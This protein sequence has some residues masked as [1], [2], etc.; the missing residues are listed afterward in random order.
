[1]AGARHTPLRRAF[2]RTAISQASDDPNSAPNGTATSPVAETVKE[3]VD[4]KLKEKGEGENKPAPE[5]APPEETTDKD[6]KEEAEADTVA[7]AIKKP[8]ARGEFGSAAAR[9]ANR[10]VRVKELPPIALPE[11]FMKNNVKRRG[12]IKREDRVAVNLHMNVLPHEEWCKLEQIETDEVRMELDGSKPVLGYLVGYEDGV[13]KV[14]LNPEC[15]EPKYNIDFTPYGE[16]LS[17]INAG[18]KLRPPKGIDAKDVIRPT[19]VIRFDKRNGSAYLDALVNTIAF[20]LKSDLVRIDCDDIAQIVGEYI[21]ENLAWKSSGKRLLGYKAPEAAIPQRR[22]KRAPMQEIED[23]GEEEQVPGVVSTDL[24]SLMNFS[25]AYQMDGTMITFQELFGQTSV[26]SST[27]SE[28]FSEPWLDFK[29]KAALEAIIDASLIKLSDEIASGPPKAESSEEHPVIIHVPGYAELI[30]TTGGIEIINKLKEIINRRWIDGRKILLIGTSV[31]DPQVP[32]TS[33]DGL[34]R[35]SKGEIVDEQRTVWI[36]GPTDWN[37]SDEPFKMHEKQRI[38]NINL[39][40]VEEMIVNMTGKPENAALMANVEKWLPATF[41]EAPDMPPSRLSQDLEDK[42]W[43]YRMIHRVATIMIGL[44][45]VHNKPVDCPLWR[46]LTL[47]AKSESDMS[48]DHLRKKYMRHGIR[49]LKSTVTV[50]ES[51]KEVRTI[52]LKTAEE[53]SK[54]L[55]EQ[56]SK[57]T[58][59]KGK[60]DAMEKIKKGCTKHEKKLLSGVVN[61]ES[62]K[63]TFA[64]IQ[65]PPETIEALK[66]LTSLSLHRPEAFSYG[67]LA[68]DKIS[69]VL[70]YGPPGTGKTLLAKAVAKESGARVLEVSGADLNDMWIGESEKNIKALFSLAKKLSPCIV[71]IDEADSIFQSR[72]AGS[73][74]GAGRNHR[75]AI[76]QFLAEWD[77][78]NDTS[79]FIMVATN[80]PFDL[81]EAVLRRLPRRLLVDLP[82]EADREAILK[83]HLQGEI[84]TADVSLADIAK[85]TPFYSGSDLKNLSIAAALACVREENA[86]AAKHAVDAAAVAAERQLAKARAKTGNDSADET[87]EETLASETEEKPAEYKYPP[88]RQLTKA[89]FEIGLQEI[90]ASISEDMSSLKD[91]RK[92]DERYGDP[93]GRK[94]RSK[95]L[96]FGT[97]E[98]EVDGKAGRV[99]VAV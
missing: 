73:M 30:N 40:H 9:R 83:I 66:T 33:R 18:L 35:L 60:A 21:G 62:I 56:A 75:Q 98:E 24:I 72:S 36:S 45:P 53:L 38:R 82:V 88:K 43:S 76:N 8:R 32:A 39:R 6:G 52:I 92:F 13:G 97:V 41:E 90:S 89:H 86:A 67:V 63:T 65:A 17:T 37:P 50:D 3:E 96:G 80:R 4:E 68:K 25:N 47:I 84:L 79:A 20:D 69:G 58:D 87:S 78:M 99:R 61:P 95:G 34:R 74:S 27:T 71:F 12:E 46:A 11:Q 48:T 29:T 28:S 51:G 1:M 42:I 10:N 54:E 2:H 93:K 5:T 57:V 16:V 14:A 70:L 44:P 85:N 19:F 94:K 55:K 31:A 15:K 91:I 26:S 22:S 59:A 7:A 77:G 23:A 81:D 64:D 49:A